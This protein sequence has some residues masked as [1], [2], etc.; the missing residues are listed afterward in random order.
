MPF[1]RLSKRHV[2]S[3]H[4]A[5]KREL[6]AIKIEQRSEEYQPHSFYYAR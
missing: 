1:K 3:L 4:K 2:S 6:I 5:F